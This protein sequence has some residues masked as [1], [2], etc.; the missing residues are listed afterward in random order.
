MAQFHYVEDYRNLVRELLK[1]H[2]LDEAMSIAVGGGWDEFGPKLSGFVQSLG[3]K[4]GMNVL[5]FGC[6]SGRLAYFLSQD[7]ELPGYVGI[8]I[9]EELLQYAADKCPPHYEFVL[10]DDELNIPVA[11]GVFDFACA[12]SVFTHLL[13]TEIMIFSREVFDALKPGGIFV[14]SFLELENHWE[15]FSGSWRSHKQHGR[16]H[17]HLNMFL[18]RNQVVILARESG[19]ELSKFIEPE[20]GIGQTSVVLIKPAE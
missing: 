2:D 4:S 11:P 13:Q 3:L 9:V 18:D 6:G 10:N 15:V 8:D 5:D 12:F 1:T 20:D 14:Y 17:P 7:L 16:P 19:F